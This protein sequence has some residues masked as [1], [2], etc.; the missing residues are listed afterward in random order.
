MERYGK[1]P[2]DYK[3]Q[4]RQTSLATPT[5]PCSP[6]LSNSRFVFEQPALPPGGDRRSMASM[7]GASDHREPQLLRYRERSNSDAHKL[8]RMG[9]KSRGEVGRRGSYL[10]GRATQ[11]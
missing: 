2:A 6:F 3:G 10:T 8:E 1:V 11:V 9:R 5:G 7:V 4:T